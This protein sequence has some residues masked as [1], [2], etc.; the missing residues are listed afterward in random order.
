MLE[1]A[2]VIAL[3][4][5]AIHIAFQQGNVLAWARLLLANGLDKLNRPVL[6]IYILKPIT[7]CLTCSASVWGSLLMWLELHGWSFWLLLTIAGVNFIIEN[8]FLNE[9]DP[10]DEPSA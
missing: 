8:L 10:S 7:D 4:I 3:Q 2:I 5:T 6:K 9:P 1:Q